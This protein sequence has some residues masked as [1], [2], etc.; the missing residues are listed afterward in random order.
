MQAF[1]SNEFIHFQVATTMLRNMSNCLVKPNED[2]SPNENVAITDFGRKCRAAFYNSDFNSKG[3]A[4]SI[5]RYNDS[6]KIGISLNLLPII[7]LLLRESENQAV[8]SMGYRCGQI[9]NNFKNMLLSADDV[10]AAEPE[11]EFKEFTEIN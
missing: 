2:N 11:S 6:A 7:G 3:T 10:A 8:A 5:K 1:T 9:C 4:F